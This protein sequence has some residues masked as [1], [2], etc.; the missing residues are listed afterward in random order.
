MSLNNKLISELRALYEQDYELC[1]GDFNTY[2]DNIIVQNG[3]IKLDHRGDQD[4]LTIADLL[5]AMEKHTKNK[6]ISSENIPILN[7]KITDFEGTKYLEVIYPSD[8]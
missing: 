8:Y 1:V 3:Y 4:Y 6:L 5:A 7:F 2:F